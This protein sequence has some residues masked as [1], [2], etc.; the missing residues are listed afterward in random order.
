LQTQTLPTFDEFVTARQPRLAGVMT[1]ISGI[2]WY[3]VTVGAIVNVVLLWIVN[4][5]FFSHM[6]LGGIGALFLGVMI[7]VI[8]AMDAPMR[9]EVSVQPEAYR[10]VHDVVM[11]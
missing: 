7:F 11:Q 8:A 2:L 9:G 6:I 5:R 4:A 10:L 1:R 3:A